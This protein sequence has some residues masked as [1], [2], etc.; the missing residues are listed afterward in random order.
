MQENNFNYHV[1]PEQTVRVITTT[2]AKCEADDQYAIVHALL[3][4][5]FDNRGFVAVHFGDEISKTSMMDSCHEIE[6]IFDIMEKPQ[7]LIFR[8]AEHALRDEFTPVPSEGA[9]LII[10]EAMSDEKTP[11]FVTCQG[12][13]TDLASAYLMEPAIASRLTAIWIGGGSY[14][15]GGDEFNLGNDINAANVVMKSTIPL[16]QVP[17]P[18]YMKM[19][20]SLAELEY[21]V[22]PCGEI[23][24]YLFDQLVENSDIPRVYNDEVRSGE[25]WFLGDSPVVGLMM[26]DHPECYTW[27]EAPESTP[28]MHYVQTH[29]NRPIRV[30]HDI[31]ARY[32]LEDFYAKLSLYEQSKKK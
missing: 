6:R 29:K 4:P 21:R 27:V 19:R 12:A 7:E 1:Y 32:I 28:Q 23:G 15:N 9:K 25:V 30:Y 22:R 5:K 31:D 18:T 10:R 17:R 24:R 2:D 26:W 3:T 16:W 20:V 8:G 11:L 13:I 14:P